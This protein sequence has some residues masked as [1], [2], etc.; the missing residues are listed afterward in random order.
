MGDLRPSVQCPAPT[1]GIALRAALFLTVAVLVSSIYANLSF[2]VKDAANYRFFPPFQANVNINRNYEL[3][4]EYYQ[5]ARSLA[6]G[7]GFAS[8]F[9][10]PTGPTAW[11]PPLLP[12]VL[13][14][15]LWACDGNR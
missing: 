13:A 12:A 6:A 2:V 9:K 15:L 10:E 7:D 3:G 4:G 11:M 8:P 5:I 1:R 14:A